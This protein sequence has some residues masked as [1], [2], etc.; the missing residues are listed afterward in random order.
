MSADKQLIIIGAGPAG[1]TAAIYAARA[2]MDFLVL[3][4]NFTGGGQ[5]LNTGKID[6]YPGLPEITGGELAKRLT[7]HV[8]RLGITVLPDTVTGLEKEGR[9]FRIHCEGGKLY[10]ASTVIIA[11]GTSHRK[12]GVPGEEELAGSGVSYCAAC[13]GA[14]FKDKTVAVAGGGNSAA[15]D[16]L[17]LAGVCRK[18]MLIHRRD[19]FRADKIL[20]DRL[21]ESGNVELILSSEILR[22]EGT[23]FVTGVQ[24]RNKKDQSESVL[25]TDGVFIAIGTEPVT[26]WCAKC[27]EDTVK[28]DE[29]GYLEAG[30]DC[31]TEL[32][33]L[34]AAGDIRKKKLRQIVTAMSDGANAAKGV[35][36]Y[37]LTM[38]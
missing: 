19:E 21:K 34:F 4:A 32:P 5:I 30:E 23:D 1:L 29:Q 2:K 3:D 33:G 22:I 28:R 37:L 11:A 12:L 35:Q 16:A 7:D 18:V 36:E 31:R 20:V 15:E 27:G 9:T 17:Y 8:S 24:I 10:T 38:N 6:N 13:D 14:F 26:D 25:P